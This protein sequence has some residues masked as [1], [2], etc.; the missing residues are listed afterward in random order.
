MDKK[1]YIYCMS[2]D[3]GYETIRDPVSLK[4]GLIDP[5]GQLVAP[6]QYD[7]IRQS[8]KNERLYIVQ[9][10][11][12]HLWGALDNWG[13][14]I[15]PCEFEEVDIFTY[16]HIRARKKGLYGIYTDYGREIVP[17]QYRYAGLRIRTF[18]EAKPIG[19]FYIVQDPETNLWGLI[20]TNK[21]L[22]IPLTKERESDV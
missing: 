19:L 3:N 12:T 17:C 9:D 18:G 20:N 11:E 13:D 10:P 14:P 21:E 15:L 22:I 7:S 5:I 8:V 6:C 1:E 2:Y 4:E 16:D